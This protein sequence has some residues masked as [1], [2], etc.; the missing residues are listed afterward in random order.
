MLVLK[1][2]V[3][4]NNRIFLLYFLLI[5]TSVCSTKAQQVIFNRFTQPEGSFSG[6]V[7]G[8]SQDPLGYMWFAVYD[9]GLYRSDGYHLVTYQHDP[10][11]PGSLATNAIEPVYADHNGIVW[12]G[13][14]E[15]G[16]VVWI[17]IQKAL[18]GSDY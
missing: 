6:I 18:S 2:M 9:R 4:F 13:T 15:S 10:L 3:I 12:V 1:Q 8:I 5:L 11:N 14:Q 17:L 7:N 16:L